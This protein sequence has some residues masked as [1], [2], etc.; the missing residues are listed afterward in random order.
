M[1]V[2]QLIKR[3][4][5]QLP[6]TT[7]ERFND[8]SHLFLT[9]LARW[10]HTFNLTGVRSIEEMVAR[11]LMDSLVL[12]PYLTGSDIIDVGSGA[13]LPGIPLAILYP[14]KHFLLLDSNGKKTR[15]ITQA[16]IA[17]GLDNVTVHQGRVQEYDQAT[18]DHVLCR[19]F[20]PLPKLSRLVAH[21]VRQDGN[22]LAMKGSQD[23][24]AAAD[25]GLVVTRVIELAVP[26]LDARRSVVELHRLPS[27][28]TGP[29]DA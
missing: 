28:R 2:R 9:R 12:A 16:S 3:G 20:A 14:D 15:F 25:S 6:F 5:A 19:A 8:L 24:L 26:L 18:F 27:C 21:L 23:E 17:L 7:D 1:P 22:V 11:H 29:V 13:G 10:N 4:L